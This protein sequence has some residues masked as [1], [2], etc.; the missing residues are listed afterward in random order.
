[1]S[2]SEAD[3]SINTNTSPHYVDWGAIIAG[4]LVAVAVSSMFIAFGSAIGL[5]LTSFQSGSSASGTGVVIA[6]ALWFLWVEVSSFMV[7]GYLAG[8]LRRRIGDSSQHESE[9]RDGSHGLVVWAL[10]VV[11]GLIL[12]SLLALHGTTLAL[13]SANSGTSTSATDYYVD[14]L[15]RSDTATPDAGAAVPAPGST[16]LPTVNGDNSAVSRNLARSVTSS[17]VEDGD[18]SF[19]VNEISRRTGLSQADAQARLDQTI[20]QMK[21]QAD[22]A[23]RY[24]VLFAFLT[25]ASLLVG[26]VAAWW[27][28][29]MGGKHRNEGTD[30]SHLTRWR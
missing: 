4:S 2:M 13:T 3:I 23:R 27:A 20:A 11:A 18:R 10:G 19:L 30:F 15:L 21:A 17:S 25:A 14:R 1:M 5:S 6:A 28:A 26:A 8:R 29:T 7:G 22:R 9:V 24:G 16:T 12:A